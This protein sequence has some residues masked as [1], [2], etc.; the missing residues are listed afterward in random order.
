GSRR[1]RL[2]CGRPRGGGALR[3]AAMEMGHYSGRARQWVTWTNLQDSFVGKPLASHGTTT[4]KAFGSWR[5]SY[6]VRS[7]VLKRS[8]G[9]RMQGDTIAF[10]IDYDGA[11][12]VRSDLMFFLQHFSAV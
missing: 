2:C 5:R 7:P 12:T 3:N 8:D 6:K 9:R 10:R 11:K 1:N 4:P